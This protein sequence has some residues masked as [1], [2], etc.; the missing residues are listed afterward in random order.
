MGGWFFVNMKVDKFRQLCHD[1]A[2]SAWIIRSC[3]NG[4]TMRRNQ[5]GRGG[6]GR[7][8]D[9]AST[10]GGGT[11]SRQFEVYASSKFEARLTMLREALLPQSRTSRPRRRGR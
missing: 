6:S 9:Q 4:G 3:G 11:Y 8:R 7:S 2:S 1:G 5:V 10:V